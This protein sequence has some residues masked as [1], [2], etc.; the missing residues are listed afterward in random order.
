[1]LGVLWGTQRLAYLHPVAIRFLRSMIQPLFPD[2]LYRPFTPGGQ[3][4]QYRFILSIHYIRIP[5]KQLLALRHNHF[6]YTLR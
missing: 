1:M 5:S 4:I 6:R 2:R 3:S